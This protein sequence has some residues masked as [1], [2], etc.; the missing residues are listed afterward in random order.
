MQMVRCSKRVIELCVVYKH[1]TEIIS[2]E[3]NY[4]LLIKLM[5]SNLLN[6]SYDFKSCVWLWTKLLSTQSNYYYE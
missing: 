3:N 5:I 1:W 2:R 4:N 6:R